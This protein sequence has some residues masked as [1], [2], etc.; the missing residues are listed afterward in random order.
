MSAAT[1]Q[2]LEKFLREQAQA[3]VNSDTPLLDARMIAQFVLGVDDAGLIL[4]AQEVVSAQDKKLIK[5]HVER[6]AKGEPV[7][8]I[9]GEKEFRSLSFKMHPG[10]LVPRPDS[11]T[12][13]EAVEAVRSKET[14]LRILD[15]GVGTG[16]L[17][18][19]LL[20]SFP[21]ATGVGVD[22]NIDAVELA[23]E[24]AVSLGVDDRAEFLCGDWC[25]AVAGTFD[26]IISNPPYIRTGDVK[27][28]APD[29][30]DYEDKGALFA[31]PDG[32]D[33]YK[34]VLD[35]AA[36]HLS[37]GGL[38]VLELGAG[39]EQQVRELAAERLQEARIYTK[40]DLAGVPRALIAD[41]AC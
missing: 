9:T 32:L 28:L 40:P 5:A 6:R 25:N 36:N 22:R 14:P 27:T 8:Y 3:L 41:C 10:V 26:V 19:A 15:L 16:C 30:L 23:K 7:A 39:Q 34:K 38:A 35:A 1:P 11:E 20:K 12:L 31:G 21:N 18:L 29:I 33:A 13:I 37:Q 24:N 17:L 2:T 4:A